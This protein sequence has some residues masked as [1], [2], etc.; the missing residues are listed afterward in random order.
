MG[1]SWRVQAVAPSV[2]DAALAD[3]VMGVLAG[4]ITEMSPWE[5]DSDISRFNRAPADSRHALPTDFATV[6]AASLSIAELSNGAFDPTAGAAVDLWGFGPPGPR[7]TPPPP[8]APPPEAVADACRTIGWRRLDWQAGDRTLTQPGGTRLDLS[9]IAKGFAVDKVT[10]WLRGIGVRASLVE[11]GGELAGHGIKPDGSPWWV[12][13]ERPSADEGIPTRI[14]LH[15]LAVATSGDYR[16]FFEAAGRHF[17][18]SIDPRTATPIANRVA[19]VSVV[20]DRCMTADGWATA[21]L[22][23]GEEVGMALADRHRIAALFIIRRDGRLIERM[24][25]AM[26]EMLD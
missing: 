15:G 5:P 9:A 19:S 4:V 22:V 21:L 8:E 12:E 2:T 14:A 24:T 1:T 11:L 7:N 3:G 16:R 6:M 20:A 23:L 17:A 10:S 26:Q 18:H 13:L 25:A